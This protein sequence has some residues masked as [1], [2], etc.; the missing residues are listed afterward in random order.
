[1]QA[2]HIALSRS[3]RRQR[4][5]YLA[6]ALIPIVI[7]FFSCQGLKLPLPG[8]P[9][10]HFAGVPCPAWGLTRSFIATAK[11]DWQQ[12]ITYHLFGPVLFLG[13]LIAGIHILLELVGGQKIPAFYLPWVR[14]PKLQLWF[15]VVL[16][17]YHGT[18]LYSLARSGELYS[19]FAHSPLSHFF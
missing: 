13:F 12:A 11:G 5:F 14:K 10:L 16:F 1:M 4:F 15:F 17:S 2:S 3:E 9:L 19:S 18:R 7:S 8:C 6:I